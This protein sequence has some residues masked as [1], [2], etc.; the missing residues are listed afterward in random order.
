MRPG[1]VSTPPRSG[2][3]SVIVTRKE[4]TRDTWHHRAGT[5][6]KRFLAQVACQPK[7]PNLSIYYVELV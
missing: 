6:G 5:P 1:R 2:A 4:T 3:V 7:M